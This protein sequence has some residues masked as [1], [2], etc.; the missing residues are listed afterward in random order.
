MSEYLHVC[1]SKSATDRQL[2]EG[3]RKALETNYS[4]IR[5]AARREWE[6]RCAT[7]D[8]S[9]ACVSVRVTRFALN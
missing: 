8:P 1:A 4:R 7:R 6:R 3:L 5:N 9:D 2:I